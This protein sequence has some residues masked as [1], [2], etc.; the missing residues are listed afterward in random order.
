MLVKGDP[1]GGYLGA[2]Y[3][4]FM[5]EPSDIPRRTNIIKMLFELTRAI[6]AVLLYAVYHLMGMHQ[7][8]RHPVIEQNA[9]E[10]TDLN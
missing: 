1:G 5:K 3:L 4:P 6:M 9:S 8:T 2:I 10:N 7:T